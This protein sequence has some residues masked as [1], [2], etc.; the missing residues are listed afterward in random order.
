LETLPFAVTD[1]TGKASVAANRG[2]ARLLGMVA[3]SRIILKIRRA[4]LP[5]FYFFVARRDERRR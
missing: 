1:Q 3:P 5:I 4:K 2:D